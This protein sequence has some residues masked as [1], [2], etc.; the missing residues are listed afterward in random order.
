MDIWRVTDADGTERMMLD[1]DYQEWLASSNA[2][3]RIEA[4]TAALQ[5]ISDMGPMS[6][7][8]QRWRI[9]RDTLDALGI[10]QNAPSV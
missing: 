8:D 7:D 3:Q 2:K 4:L 6:V 9:A 1:D 10:K 5:Q